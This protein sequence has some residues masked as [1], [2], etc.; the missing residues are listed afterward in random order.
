M[1]R[2]TSP[3]SLVTVLAL[4]LLSMGP[5]RAAAQDNSVALDGAAAEYGRAL[6]LTDRDQRL[7]AFQRAERQ[8][9]NL[10]E[11]GTPDNADLWTNL[12]NAALG[13]EK[14][15]EAIHAYRTA[16]RLDP[17]HPRA[18][19]NLA[20]ARRLLPGWVPRPSEGGALDTF[21]FWHKRLS[22]A[23]RRAAQ[24]FFFLLAAAMLAAGIAG[25][26]PWLRHLTALPLIAWTAL[27]VTTPPRASG[28]GVIVVDDTVGRAADSRNAPAK[29]AEPLPAGAEV[30]IE[31]E[32][33]GW[34]DIRLSNGRTAWVPAASV[35]RVGTP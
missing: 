4:L 13:G 30:V 28:E 12:G 10:I 6:E 3:R 8:F 23:E 5:V 20:H 25:R 29:F 27:L 2:S 9:R 26:R 17:D 33:D 16:L 24:A 22:P 32:R 7:A 15:G 34:R 14:L 19:G 1:S 35:R 11:N 31:E 21:L 18:Q